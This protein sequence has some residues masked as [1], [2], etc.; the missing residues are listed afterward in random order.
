M[1]WGTNVLGELILRHNPKCS[2]GILTFW[3]SGPFYFTELLIPALH[4]ASTPERKSRVINLSSQMGLLGISAFGSGL[5]FSTFKDSPTRRKA[6]GYPLYS[7]SK[8]V[9]RSSDS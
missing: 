5:D 3:I 8:L 2:R 4:K 1:T 7:Q 6:T 9:S